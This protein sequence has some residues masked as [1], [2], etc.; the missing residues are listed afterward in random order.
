VAQTLRIKISKF[1]I[2]IGS[3]IIATMSRTNKLLKKTPISKSAMHSEP[4]VTS[5]DI[6]RGTTVAKIGLDLLQLGI[7]VELSPHMATTERESRY[8]WL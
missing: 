1:Q 7:Y 4:P 2:L 5:V 8:C 3:D 6:F